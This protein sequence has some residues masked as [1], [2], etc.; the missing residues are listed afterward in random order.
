MSYKSYHQSLSTNERC[1]ENFACS[2]QFC[3]MSLLAAVPFTTPATVI[4]TRCSTGSFIESLYIIGALFHLSSAIWLCYVVLMYARWSTLS[5]PSP[6]S[7]HRTQS[8]LNS[9]FALSAHFKQNVA[10]R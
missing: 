10:I 6:R 9:F 5:S 7:S 3:L 4:F 8:M 2:K 1:A